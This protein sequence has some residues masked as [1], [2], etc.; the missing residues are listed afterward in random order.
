MAHEPPAA[1]EHLSAESRKLWR[2]LTHEY[3]LEP[4][5]LKTFRLALEA[6]DRATQA[7]KAIRRNGLTYEDRFGAPHVRPEVGIERDARAAWARLMRELA[8][9]VDDE[10]P[11]L[12]LRV[13]GDRVKAFRKAQERAA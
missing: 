12:D 2:E 11:K 8:L 1:P 5:E 3:E 4:H 9:P 6:L 13:R 7:R 10:E